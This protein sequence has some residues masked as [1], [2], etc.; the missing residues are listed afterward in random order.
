MTAAQFFSPVS[1]P[2]TIFAN[3]PA[4]LGYYPHESVILLGFLRQEPDRFTL[5]PI[6]RSDCAAIDHDDGRAALHS[7]FT[8][9]ENVRAEFM[10]ALIVSTDPRRRFRSAR[11]LYEVDRERVGEVHVVACF[12]AVEICTREPYWLSWSGTDG[13]LPEAWRCGLIGNVV[14]APAMEPFRRKGELPDLDRESAYRFFD[15]GNPHMDDEQRE[16]IELRINENT[17]DLL[18]EVADAKHSGHLEGWREEWRETM[19]QLLAEVARLSKA[20]LSAREDLLARLGLILSVDATRDLF[21]TLIGE[22]SEEVLAASIVA[23]R[24]FRGVIRCNA[25]CAYSAA[26]IV[27]G[28]PMRLYPALVASLDEDPGHSLTHLLLRSGM[29]G[30]FE[31]IVSAVTR[32]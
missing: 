10:V 30:A 3:L 13:V 11:R 16:S 7:A 31:K 6:L 4:I 24:T 32:S 18:R 20:E 14:A 29:T 27:E 28:F 9:M 15:H 23:A 26:S 22:H 5:G 17:P 2:S 21:M 8:H 1:S 19:I 12:E 25:L